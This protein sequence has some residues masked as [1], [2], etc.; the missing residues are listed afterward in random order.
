MFQTVSLADHLAI[1][2]QA[3]PGFA[4]HTNHPDLQESTENLLYKIYRDFKADIPFGLRIHLDKRIPLGGGLGGGSG[5]AAGFLAY[6]NDA[7]GWGFSLSGLIDIGMRYGSDVPFF[8]LG[9]TALVEGVGERLSVKK[10]A[11]NGCFV[12]ANPGIHVGTPGVFRAFDKLGLGC[13]ADFAASSDLEGGALGENDLAPVVFRDYPVYTQLASVLVPLGFPFHLS[14][15][16]ATVFVPVLDVGS[17]SAL[18]AQ[19]TPKLPGWWFSVVESVPGPGY[20]IS[21]DLS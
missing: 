10:P 20:R 4:L 19:L 14:G 18:V 21:S 11:Y 6:L 7:C 3:S 12:L 13:S 8:F 17:G 9:G 2:T 16:G 15:S 1:E 5:N